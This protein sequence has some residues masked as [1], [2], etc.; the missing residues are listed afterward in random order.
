MSFWRLKFWA[1][2]WISL[3]NCKVS[4][5]FRSS[6]E[7]DL[8]KVVSLEKFRFSS[9][10]TSLVEWKKS[11]V[12]KCVTKWILLHLLQRTRG[13]SRDGVS[14][15]SFK[16]LAVVLVGERMSKN[17]TDN[18]ERWRTFVGGDE[19]VI[20]YIKKNLPN[21]PYVYGHILFRSPSHSEQAAIICNC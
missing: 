11:R 14:S 4:C 18:R 2:V 7:W 20:V 16:S 9:L 13:C 10:S 3:W 21:S 12:K 17:G 1:V 8:S 19:V 6:W 15:I 5:F